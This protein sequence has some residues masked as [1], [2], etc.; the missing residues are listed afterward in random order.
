MSR[1]SVLWLAAWVAAVAWVAAH[2][3]TEVLLIGWI[4][5]AVAFIVSL[6][7]RP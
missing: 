5:A 1:S 3:W 6:T 7:W 4:V 2:G